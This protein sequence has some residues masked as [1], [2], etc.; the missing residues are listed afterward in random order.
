MVPGGHPARRG[1][2][3]PATGVGCPAGRRAMS[4]ESRRC[5]TWRHR[6]RPEPCCLV[7]VSR[8]LGLG[9]ALVWAWRVPTHTRQASTFNS[10][11][12][13]RRVT[14]RPPAIH[15]HTSF[16]PARPRNTSPLDTPARLRPQALPVTLRQTVSRIVTRHG[17]QAPARTRASNDDDEINQ[18]KQH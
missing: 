11:A 17:C 7:H 16:R 1:P 2:A 12:V 13:L 18:R 6:R 4:G 9:L 10:R 5:Q 3:P 15:H 8:A 14:S